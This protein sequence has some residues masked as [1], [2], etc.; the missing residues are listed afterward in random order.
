MYTIT[1]QLTISFTV[2]SMYIYIVIDQMANVTCICVSEFPFK[3]LIPTASI[4]NFVV[5]VLLL[6][7]KYSMH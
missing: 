4:S 7:N 5:V 3:L 6:Q 2:H 1:Q